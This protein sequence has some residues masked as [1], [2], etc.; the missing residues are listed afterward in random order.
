MKILN[1][2][3]ILKREFSFLSIVLLISIALLYITAALFILNYRFIVQTVEGDFPLLYKFQILFGLITGVSRVFLP[4]EFLLFIITSLLIGINITLLGKAI[5]E[6]KKQNSLKLSFGG[7]VLPMMGVGC[8]SC[9]ITLLSFLGP[10]TSIVL[11][12]FQTILLQLAGIVLLA[13][14][15]F[16]IL[17]NFTPSHCVILPNKTRAL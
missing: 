6:L 10:S 8:P 16:S 5:R 3:P 4:L 14:S 7:V 17:K 12:P 2:I 1:P 15:F 11:L 9:G 13:L